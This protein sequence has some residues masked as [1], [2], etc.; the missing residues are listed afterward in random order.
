MFA[1]EPIEDPF[2]YS[3]DG[4]GERRQKTM[5]NYN[6]AHMSPT[7]AYDSEELGF[8][9]NS[10]DTASRPISEAR[11]SI[12][13]GQYAIPASIL[14]QHPDL[15][16]PDTPRHLSHFAE[17]IK[18]TFRGLF[19]FTRPRD[20]FICFVPGFLCSATAA[21]VQP[22]MSKII[23][24]AF[25]VFVRYPLDPA[26]ATA[27]DKDALMKGITTSTL[28]LVGAGLAALVLNYAKG[29]LWARNGELVVDRLRK[30]VFD[31]VQSKGMTWFDTGMGL[32]EEDRE[33]GESIGAGGLMA[34]FT[35]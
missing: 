27:G 9:L 22:F 19:F 18:P 8:G 13:P 24:E 25:D 10:L 34:K 7:G 4:H 21:A 1:D 5:S 6:F 35:K 14:E 32:R 23:G 30:A 20:Y 17:P 28:K 11:R 12:Y 15:L 16:P 29:A 33:E 26:L 31:G 2:E 3:Q